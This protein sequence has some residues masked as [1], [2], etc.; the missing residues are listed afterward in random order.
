MTRRIEVTP[1]S[2]G[3]V[4]LVCG[5]EELVLTIKD[6][7][8]PI[9]IDT[10]TPQP[11]ATPK[12]VDIRG[13]HTFSMPMMFDVRHV[14]GIVEEIARGHADPASPRVD[15]V[16]LTGGQLDVHRVAKL[17]DSLHHMLP[18]VGLHVNLADDIL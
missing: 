14:S 7:R 3:T 10:R 15:Q 1:D 4:V 5:D 6:H 16:M 9:V 12:I 17:A 8:D 13:L 18:G 2:N 11:H